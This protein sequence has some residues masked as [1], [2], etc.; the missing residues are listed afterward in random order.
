MAILRANIA[1]LLYKGVNTVFGLAY[2]ELPEEWPAAF[3]MEKSDKAFEEDVLATGFG[4]AVVKEEGSD[5]TFDDARTAWAARYNHDTI[6]L[7]F[8][9][10]EEAIED[11]LYGVT[12]PKFGKALARSFVQTKEIKA[13]SV[14]N[15]GFSAFVGGDGVAMLSTSH[16]TVG[17]GTFANTFSTQADLSEASLEDMLIL[18]R[19]TKDDRGIPVALRPLRL[20]I[21][22]DN[23]FNATRLTRSD[24]R[25]DTANNDINAIKAKGIFTSDASVLTRLTDPDAWF[26]KTDC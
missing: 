10:T 18:I 19:K 6:G 3:D 14:L 11:D 21:S 16:P 2:S 12:V 8:I 26:V 1:K 5:Y 20:I 13:A 17:A 24:L 4:A 23:I 22:P 25:P 7:G 15:N 9:I